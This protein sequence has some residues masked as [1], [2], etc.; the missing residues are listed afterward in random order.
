MLGLSFLTYVLTDPL[1][2][3]LSHAFPSP[4]P[5]VFPDPFP[6]HL[7]CNSILSPGHR[8]LLPL[9]MHFLLTPQFEE[10][11]L[12]QPCWFPAFPVSFPT[13]WDGE[14]LHTKKSNLKEF[15]AVVSNSVS[16]DSYPGDLIHQ[17]LKRLRDSSSKVQSPGFSSP[18]S[19]RSL[20]QPGHGC[21]IP[22]CL[23]Y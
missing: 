5:S 14:L 2:V 21:Y 15:P 23:Q 16:K 11:I 3:I 9:A 6:T 17:L 13:H 8:S 12:G 7:N 18:G 1:L 20:T 19:L 22:V 10:Q 4:V